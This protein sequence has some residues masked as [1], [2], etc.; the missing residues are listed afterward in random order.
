MKIRDIKYAKLIKACV[1]MP[2]LGIRKDD[3]FST[4]EVRVLDTVRE[5]T[6]VSEAFTEDVYI[7]SIVKITDLTLEKYNMCFT[8]LESFPCEDTAND[9]KEVVADMSKKLDPMNEI[10]EILSLV[11]RKLEDINELIHGSVQK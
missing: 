8:L 2:E 4:D 10:N 9:L 3:V 5:F 1:N 11:Y 7:K 6:S